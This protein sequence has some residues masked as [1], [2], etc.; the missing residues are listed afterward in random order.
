MIHIQ[1]EQSWINDRD[2]IPG[3][4]EGK[5]N[6]CLFQSLCCINDTIPECRERY[7]GLIRKYNEARLNLHTLSI[8]L[9]D[10]YLIRYQIHW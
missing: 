5:G 1:H 2:E 4:V 10:Y 7:E 3:K 9:E 6:D 8:R